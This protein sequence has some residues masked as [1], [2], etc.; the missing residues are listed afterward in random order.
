VRSSTPL[1]AA[2]EELIGHEARAIHAQLR[3]GAIAFDDLQQMGR[4]GA[5]EARQRY[6]PRQGVHFKLY[7]RL[8][9]RGAM[10][11][12]LRTMGLL[13]RREYAH[14][15]QR[16]IDEQVLG[17]PQ[18][19]PAGGPTR[20]NDAKIMFDA[21]LDLATARIA[22]MEEVQESAEVEY[23][24]HDVIYRVRRAVQA[25]PESERRAIRAIYDFAEKGDSGAKAAARFGVS[26]SQISRRHQKALEKL[27][28]MLQLE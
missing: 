10:F 22:A 14:L 26:R 25:L 18:P 8:R 5:L 1:D 15:R 28:R 27:R 9:V 21:I 23:E 12:G 13:T 24:Q 3:T 4:L 19:D 2:V 11:D 7:A 16:A 17:D 6:D 20:E